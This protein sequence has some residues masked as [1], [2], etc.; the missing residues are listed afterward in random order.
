MHIIKQPNKAIRLQTKQGRYA[1]GQKTI[2]HQRRH[3]KGQKTT[4]SSPNKKYA[5]NVN[6]FQTTNRKKKQAGRAPKDQG[7]HMAQERGA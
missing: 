5:I 4:I 7:K 6:N 3:V 1:P 2:I